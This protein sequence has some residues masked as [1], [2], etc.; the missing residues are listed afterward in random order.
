MT[1]WKCFCGPALAFA[2]TL[3]GSTSAIAGDVAS[4]A[5]TGGTPTP[6]AREGSSQCSQSGSVIKAQLLPPAK[7]SQTYAV[8]EGVNTAG[9]VRVNNL[10]NLEQCL[11]GSLQTAN[12]QPASS[13]LN[14]QIF[15]ETKQAKDTTGSEPTANNGTVNFKSPVYRTE[16]LLL[17]I[18]SP[19]QILCI[20]WGAPTILWGILKLG[21]RDGGFKM[22]LTGALS[23]MVGM[24]MPNFIDWLVFSNLTSSLSG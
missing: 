19:V 16:S 10:A 3:A 20:A 7:E 5:S 1:S 13:Q 4:S 2:M 9:T 11:E 18:E 12:T 14:V 8:I 6:A 23:V 15:Q 21:A 22:F 17:C 24:V